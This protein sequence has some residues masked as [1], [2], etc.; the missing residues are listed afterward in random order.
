MRRKCELKPHD[1]AAGEPLLAYIRIFLCRPDMARASRF[2]DTEFFTNNPMGVRYVLFRFEGRRVLWALSARVLHERCPGWVREY[3]WKHSY[4]RHDYLSRVECVRAL[5]AIMNIVHG[6]YSSGVGDLLPASGPFDNPFVSSLIYYRDLF[7]LAPLVDPFIHN[8]LDHISYAGGQ[9]IVG[10]KDWPLL[11]PI[12]SHFKC[13]KLFDMLSRRFI[14]KC[15]VGWMNLLICGGGTNLCG[16]KTEEWHQGAFH[17]KLYAL[18]YRSR[19]VPHADGGPL[20]DIC[21]AALEFLTR[22]QAVVNEV[23]VFLQDTATNFISRPQGHSKQRCARVIARQLM[24]VRRGMTRDGRFTTTS[25]EDIVEGLRKDDGGNGDGDS[26]SIAASRETLEQVALA[27]T[28]I[29]DCRIS[30]MLFLM[31]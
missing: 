6:N 14:R 10:L 12:C 5:R 1:D 13:Q 2:S 28:K 23:L 9:Y 31:K 19:L 21:P 8:V 16:D 11:L 17:Y 20:A 29:V 24:Q 26:P 30:H 7:E 22:R 3:E 4:P 27:A 18:L 25:L 15:R